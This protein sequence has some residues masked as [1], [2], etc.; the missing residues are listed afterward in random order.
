[1]NLRL[2]LGVSAIAL[3]P[4]VAGAQDADLKPCDDSTDAMT[5]VSW[6]GAYQTSQQKA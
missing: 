1:M 5:V 4:L 3:L 2:L 6:G